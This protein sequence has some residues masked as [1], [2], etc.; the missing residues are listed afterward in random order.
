MID[1]VIDVALT[2]LVLLAI[3]GLGRALRR[4]VPLAFWS[5]AADLAYS[6]AF[7]LGALT[8]LLFLLSLVGWLRPAAGWIVLAGGL[9]LAGWQHRQLLD[10]LCALRDAARRLAAASWFVKGAALLGLVFGLINL[11]ADLAPPVEGDTVHQYLLV[12]RHWVAAGRYVQ[13]AHIWAATL[14]GNMMMLSAWAL[15]LRH[16]YS[17]ATLVTGFGMS[18]LLALG[19]YSLARLY[20]GR[21]P[22]GLAAIA[23]YTMPD[24]IYLAQS[25]KVDMG[26]AFFEALALAAVFRWMDLARQQPPS[27][28]SRPLRWLILAGVCLGWAA[29]SKN[30]TLISVALLGV[31]IVAWQAFRRDWR[32]AAGAGL[33]FGLATLAAALPY[34]A[35][36]GIVHRNPFYPVF[37]DRFTAWFGATPS[38]RSE[39]GTEVF[40]PWTVIGYL[41]NAWNMSLGH[42]PKF[43]LGTLVGPIFL[44]ALPVGL[45]LGMLRGERALW[46]ML[47]YAFVF[48]IVW[49][50]VK[51]AA[52]HFLPGLILLAVVTGFILWR[53]DQQGTRTG[54]VVLAMAI[55][56]L[57]GNLVS[58]L[59]VLYWNGAY[60]VALGIE[61]RDEYLQRWHDEVIIESFPDWETITTLNE[62]LGPADRVLTPHGGSLLYIEPQVVSDVWGDR[63][64]Y[65]IISQVDVLLDTLARNN[66]RYIL[67]YKIDP[68]GEAL[69]TDPAFL[70][71]HAELLYDGPRTRLYRITDSEGE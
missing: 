71:D 6:L 54:R 9:A 67:T 11:L 1:L 30:Q 59:G 28:D 16:S 7:G 49:F 50:L 10:D 46:R 19:V 40:Y 45:I 63:E 17:L 14:P 4:F 60:R 23:I 37:A 2:A 18:L 35:Y 29:G 39:L 47:G 33:A 55:L 66:I 62:R 70:A 57:C 15:L 41:T 20:V 58:E 31:W 3:Y 64:R 24:A 13:P 22:A 38:P 68:P 48:S 44:L 51:Q 53:I 26:W 42:P 25:A 5:A 36:N 12:V 21:T 8:T 52:R 61:S 69:Y 34:Y 56:A 27:P 43:Y 65:D 32:G